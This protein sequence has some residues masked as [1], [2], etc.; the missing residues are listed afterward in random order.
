MVRILSSFLHLLPHFR[1]GKIELS[2]AECVCVRAG[3]GVKGRNTSDKWYP[4]TY[5]IYICILHS[6]LCY[7][8]VE[9]YKFFYGSC[10][11]CGKC[12]RILHGRLLSLFFYIFRRLSNSN[13]FEIIFP[14][15]EFMAFGGEL[16]NRDIIVFPM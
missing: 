16:N 8:S 10:V 14:S 11:R 4:N 15:I 3:E 9:T 12:Y 7:T 2:Q 6:N 5:T 1:N 13:Y